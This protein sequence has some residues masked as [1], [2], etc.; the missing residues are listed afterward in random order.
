[1][2]SAQSM[3]VRTYVFEYS[4]KNNSRTAKKKHRK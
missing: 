1:M 3:Y 2:M 4:E